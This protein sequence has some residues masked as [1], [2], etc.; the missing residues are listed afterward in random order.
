MPWWKN[1]GS[2]G[3][4]RDKLKSVYYTLGVMYN[5]LLYLLYWVV[6]ALMFLVLSWFF[7]DIVG[8]GGNKFIPVEAAIYSGFWLTFVVWTMWDLVISRQVKLEPEGLAFGY[9]LIVNVLGVWLVTYA[10]KYTGLQVA[11]WWV[12][13]VGAAVNSLQRLVWNWLI[14]R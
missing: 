10:V 1:V 13:V 6:N 14:K 2:R 12:W 7:P 3:G 8:L 9:F 5:H 11:G 4:T